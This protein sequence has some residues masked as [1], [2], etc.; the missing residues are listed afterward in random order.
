MNIDEIEAGPKLNALI[1]RKVMRLPGV[2]WAH[3]VHDPD[4]CKPYVA[5]D[6][7]ASA[8]SY[9]YAG[10]LPVYVAHCVCEFGNDDDIKVDGHLVHCYEP[11]DDYS[12]KMDIAWEIV[13]EMVNEGSCPALLYD[14]NGHWTLSEEG[15]Q[16][17]PE[18]DGPQEIAT[19]FF[20]EADMWYD[21][22][23]L[24]ICHTALKQETLK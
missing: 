10:K 9:R 6:G 21:T 3:C 16:N 22:A 2:T 12:G 5:H 14:D 11:V 19:V 4:G 17:M 15:M 13:E 24:A 18:S 23:P 1:A 20:I 8:C 7:E